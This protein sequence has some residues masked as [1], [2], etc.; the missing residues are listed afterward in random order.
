MRTNTL[1]WILCL[2]FVGSCTLFLTY[3]VTSDWDFILHFRGTKLIMLIIIG[4]TIAVSTLMFQTL[5]HNPILTPS[6]LGFDHLYLLI[7]T[8]LIFF[9]G[10][11]GFTQLDTNY[12]FFLETGVML[13]GSLL[14]FSLLTRNNA[15]LTRMMLIGVIF[16]VLFRNL[17]SLLKRMIAP[18]EFAIAQGSSFANFNTVNTDLIWI[19][20]SLV[21]ISLLWI[22]RQRHRLDLL[23]LGQS[24]AINLG[25]N[26]HQFS[27]Q[28]LICCALL[29]SVS[30]ALVGPILF[31]GLLVCAITNAIAPTVHHQVRLPVVFIISAITLIL[32]Q[33]FF[34]QIIN[35]QGVL[36]VVIE[37]IGGIIFIYLM[38]R[39]NK[40]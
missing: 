4:Y 25:L 31:L 37:F 33:V 30:T 18:D 24:Y 22:W 14:L 12:K 40:Q 39:K 1:I 7:Q 26:Y 23:L 15:D 3:N 2:L 27:R 11:L 9:F 16:G 28:L 6:I 38:I 13:L 35:M 19:G 36:S 32:G 10:G 20:I 8:G 29:V 21:L 17:N 5:T 34:E